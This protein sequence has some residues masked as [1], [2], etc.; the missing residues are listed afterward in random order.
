MN[1]LRLIVQSLVAQGNYKGAVI[2]AQHQEEIMLEGAGRL[3]TGRLATLLLAGY[4]RELPKEERGVMAQFV[5]EKAKE[6]A[7]N[8]PSQTEK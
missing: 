8:A 5:C 2:A 3:R 6:I 1:E 4:L 7:E